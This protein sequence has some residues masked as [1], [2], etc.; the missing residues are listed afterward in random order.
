MPQQELLFVCLQP[1][2]HHMEAAGPGVE[3]ELQLPAYATATAT[4]NP[5]HICDLCRSLR[6]CWIHNPRSEA[7]D[8]SRIF[9]ETML[10]TTVGTHCCVFS[11][12]P[13]FHQD[14]LAC[15][16]HGV[17]MVSADSR[18]HWTSRNTL[19]ANTPSAHPDPPPCL[20]CVPLPPD[21]HLASFPQSSVLV[22]TLS[23]YSADLRGVSRC[24]KPSCKG[25]EH[26]LT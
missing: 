24:S 18:S 10:G 5:S 3:L 8:Q 23:A 16:F 12:P 19:P 26:P 2:L 7:R 20:L 21:K 14:M 13:P 15:N 9:T 22:A 4:R 1:R 6:Q 17:E 11:T 25:P